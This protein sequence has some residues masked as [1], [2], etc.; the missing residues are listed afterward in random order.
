MITHKPQQFVYP[1]YI[2]PLPADDFIKGA[3]KKQEMYDAG[4]SKIREQ[5]DNYRKIRDTL[6]KDED[7][8]Y[9]DDIATQVVARINENAGLDFSFQ[10]NVN[11][12]FD[13]GTYLVDNPNV[14][15]AASSSATYRKMMEE[16]GKLDPKSKSAANDWQYFKAINDWKSDGK[17]G[18][19]LGYQAYTPYTDEHIK[20]WNTLSKEL[21][22]DIQKVYSFS[23]DGR[24]IVKEQYTGVSAERF[25][26]AYL[27]QLGSQG[28]NQLQL[29]AAYNV[30]TGDKSQMMND[31]LQADQGRYDSLSNKLNELQDSRRKAELT[32]GVDSPEVMNLDEQIQDISMKAEFYSNKL[33]NP[34]V[35]DS[36]LINHLIN[37]TVLN[38]SGTMA[39]KQVEQDLEANPYELDRHK[40]NLNIYEAQQKA[41]I[42]VAK[43]QELD[44][45]GLGSSSGGKK[46]NVPVP[47][48]AYVPTASFE[49]LPTIQSFTDLYGMVNTAEEEIQVRNAITR[50]TE[51][52][53]IQEVLDRANQEQS[54][55]PVD[56]EAI[57]KTFPSDQMKEVFLHKLKGIKKSFDSSQ[58][59]DKDGEVV[60]VT[61]GTVISVRL[62]SPAYPDGVVKDM[63]VSQFLNSPAELLTYVK[64]I[65]VK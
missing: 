30:A 65:K 43:E 46:D 27:S 63:Q 23:P 39:Y 5:V 9:F 6:V 47:P 21:K 48:G 36:A 44:R 62:V 54:W 12:M 29:E 41:L 35:S 52:K 51:N 34:D 22:P 33:N 3:I 8:K 26:E 4:I 59:V 42:D 57:S 61:G 60:K 17:V 49:G 45:L 37:E 64:D 31:M 20:L 53:T 1:D 19:S 18:S 38:A 16:Y 55:D 7:K 2:S 40:T 25:R 32:Y 50:F 13:L 56:S 14:Q 11:A 28:R 10:G 58:F 15:A 24:W